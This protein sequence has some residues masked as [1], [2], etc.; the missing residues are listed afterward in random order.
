MEPRVSI[1]IGDPTTVRLTGDLDLACAPLLKRLLTPMARAG[2]DV[3]L[4]LGGVTFLDC[5][6]VTALLR[7]HRLVQA[8]GGSLTLRH[9]SP[10][11]RRVIELTRAPL[12]VSASIDEAQA[13]PRQGRTPGTPTTGASAAV[14]A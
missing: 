4:D 14:L 7:A 9:V 5:S 13:Q 1:D 8:R 3:V 11:V 12:P 10:R 2:R 6:G